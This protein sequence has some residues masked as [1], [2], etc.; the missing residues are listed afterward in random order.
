M[1]FYPILIPLSGPLSTLCRCSALALRWI[2]RDTRIRL[3]SWLIF[4]GH[5]KDSL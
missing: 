1:A 5:M 4:L 3:S 2:W